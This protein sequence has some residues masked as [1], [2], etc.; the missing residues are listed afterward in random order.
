[1]SLSNFPLPSRVQFPLSD[2]NVIPNLS[3]MLSRKIGIVKTSSSGT[4]N[5][6]GIPT[7]S[8]SEPEV[9]SARVLERTR[10]EEN[11]NGIV[12]APRREVFVWVRHRVDIASDDIVL[13]DGERYR[14]SSPPAEVGRRQAKRFNVELVD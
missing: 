2:K 7:V 12:T 8:E 5:S 4:T 14:V 1:M 9:V 11:E 3:K 10:A 6:R 13:I